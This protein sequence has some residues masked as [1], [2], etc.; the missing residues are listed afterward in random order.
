MPIPYSAAGCGQSPGAA[1]AGL[2]PSITLFTLLILFPV[3]A[4]TQRPFDA[5][6]T[7]LQTLFTGAPLVV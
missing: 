4:S 1:C 6:F 7:A 2:W 3:L 5:G